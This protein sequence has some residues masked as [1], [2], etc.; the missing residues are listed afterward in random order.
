MRGKKQVRRGNGCRRKYS[1]SKKEGSSFKKR[2]DTHRNGGSQQ[3][4]CP[5]SLVEK[6]RVKSGE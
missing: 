6:Q 3:S 1:R 5:L 2:E 4:F